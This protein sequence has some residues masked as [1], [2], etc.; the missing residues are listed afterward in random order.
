MY[1]RVNLVEAVVEV[2][3][4][5]SSTMFQPCRNRLH[6]VQIYAITVRKNDY[7]YSWVKGPPF[8]G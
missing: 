3:T 1:M 6:D 7:P 5:F 2:R 8:G 4:R